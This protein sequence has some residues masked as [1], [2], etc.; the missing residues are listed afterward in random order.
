[1]GRSL[2]SQ[3]NG[4]EPEDAVPRDAVP[5]DPGPEPD[6]E[7]DPEAIPERSLLW[8]AGGIFVVLL[9]T[10]GVPVLVNLIGDAV[11]RSSNP[12]VTY[13]A[14]CLESPDSGPV[15]VPAPQTGVLTLTVPV[16]PS[17][18]DDA[19]VAIDESAPDSGFAYLGF[20]G[21]LTSWLCGIVQVPGQA[22]RAV[23]ERALA[24]SHTVSVTAKPGDWFCTSAMDRQPVELHV[25]TMSGRGITLDYTEWQ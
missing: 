10:V 19:G 16:N 24:D 17:A 21:Y 8:R 7:A 25:I 2:M 4:G 20:G 15:P 5:G 11:T 18:S 13:A 23:C 14:S 22:S 12:P 1:M 9:A 3:E 6:P